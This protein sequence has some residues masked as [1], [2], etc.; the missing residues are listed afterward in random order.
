MRESIIEDFFYRLRKKRPYPLSGQIELTYRCNLNCLHCYCNGCGGKEGELNIL[1]WKRILDE[2]QK[3]GCVYLILGGGEPLIREDFLELYMYAKKKGFIVTIFT[4][5]QILSSKIL[6]FL[7]KSPP[8]SLEVT[9]NGITSITYE[10]ITRV[11]GSFS[12]TLENIKKI[13]ENNL[14]LIL[15]S[16]CL[17]QNNKEIG[18]I[19]SFADNFLGKPQGGYYFKYD[20]MIYPKFNR[21]KTP[22]NF[23]LSSSQILNVRRQD[24]DIRRQ[25]KKCLSEDFPVLRRN[26][27]FLYQCDSWLNNF[28]IDPYGR[29]KFCELSS[30]FSS[31]LKT[32]SF[33]EGFYKIFPR[34]L[35]ERFRSDSKCKNCSLRPICYHCPARAYLETGDEEAPVSYYCDLAK[36]EEEARKLKGI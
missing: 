36:S 19:K 24:P 18:R 7:V 31:D 15:K 8:F 30:K 4:N 26:N 2:I 3:E 32:T 14:P 21:D 33:K 25:F 34:L 27:S 28:F 13:K 17:Q 20:P 11:K 35:K 29:L 16:N 22:T 5:G 9:L 6:N 1:E 12:K 23:R 10:A